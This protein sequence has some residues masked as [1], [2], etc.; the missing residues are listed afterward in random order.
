MKWRFYFFKGDEVLFVLYIYRQSVYFIGRDRIV[1]DIFVDYFFCFKQ[2]VVLQ[3]CLVEFQREDGLIGRRVRLYI[4]DFGLF[5]GIFVNN[6]KVDFERYVEFLEKDMIK[7][8]FSLREYVIFYEKL[9]IFEL[10]DQGVI[11][12]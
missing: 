7:F 5:N 8:G 2:Y 12:D 1:V 4:I 9:D 3:F 10:E 6:K 11:F